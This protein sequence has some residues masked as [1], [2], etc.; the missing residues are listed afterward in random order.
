MATVCGLG[1]AAGCGAGKNSVGVRGQHRDVLLLARLPIDDDEPLASAARATPRIIVVCH[2]VGAGDIRQRVA[3][4][5]AL[6]SLSALSD[7]QR[8]GGEA[9]SPSHAPT[10]IGTPI[11]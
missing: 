9:S 10:S 1:R 3:P 5:A 6:D 4:L 8:V 7:T 11:T 2:A